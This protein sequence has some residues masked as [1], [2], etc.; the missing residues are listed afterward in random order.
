MAIPREGAVAVVSAKED[1][2][3]EDE[4]SLALRARGRVGVD[5]G[6]GK[7]NMFSFRNQGGG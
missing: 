2:P 5:V 1:G 7:G 6:E 3:G 4:T